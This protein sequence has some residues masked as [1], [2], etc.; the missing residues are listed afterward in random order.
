[1]IFSVEERNITNRYFYG[2]YLRITQ[3]CIN[4]LGNAVK[5][6]P[7]GGKISFLVEQIP[8]VKGANHARYRFAV[9]DTGIGMSEDF[10][11]HI[12][13]PFTR[14]H[15]SERVEGTGLG[16]SITKGLVDLM[17]GEISVESR[18]NKGTTFCF[19][20]ECRIADNDKLQTTENSNEENTEADE[21]MLAGRNFLVAE[22]NA[23]NSEIL[24]EIL[25]MYGA[26]SDVR[27]D[28]RKALQAFVD[29]EPGTYD[30]VLM[31]IKMPNMNGYEATRAIRELNRADAK[32]IPI[33]AMT[34]NAFAEDIQESLEAGMTAHIAKPID[35]NIL[36]DTLKR[37]LSVKNRK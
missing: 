25:L 14:N 18:I 35:I 10:I 8:S 34:A 37:L 12:F 21:Q 7:E 20:L 17:G 24:C 32:T 11:S 30:A 28:G 26:T 22:D 36:G 27:T 33:I 15:K 3:I 6:T 5:F 23:I 19:E 1:M 2:D 29:S 31:D 9:K 13:E 4:I 16:L